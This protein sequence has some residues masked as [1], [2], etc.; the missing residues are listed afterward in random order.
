M[1]SFNSPFG[2]CPHC[3][4]LGEIMSIDPEKIMPDMNKRLSDYGCIKG[5]TGAGTFV[6]SISRMYIEGLCNHYG[7]NPTTKLKDLP[8]DFMDVLLYGSKGEKIK[9]VHRTKMSD[10]AFEEEFEGV[11]NTLQRRC[12]DTKSQGMKTYYEGFMSSTH[13]N[14]CDG[15]RLKKKYLQ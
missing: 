5:W 11:V 15:A 6:D 8:K 13:C 2:A 10:K 7:V 12:N 1:F 14:Y 3:T 9:F 4:G